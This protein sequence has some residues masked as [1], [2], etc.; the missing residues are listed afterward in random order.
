[1]G[2]KDGLKSIFGKIFGKNDPKLL[3]EKN[4]EQEEIN[5]KEKARKTEIR[6][7]QRKIKLDF[8]DSIKLNVGYE[9]TEKLSGIDKT[10]KLQKKEKVFG[11]SNIK[12]NI[13]DNI[14]LPCG[15]YVSTSE[16]EQAIDRALD[17]NDREN[18][19]IT[20]KEKAT[21]KS[22]SVQEL[23][24]KVIESV[25]EKVKIKLVEDSKQNIN[26]DTL[27]ISLENRNEEWTN[28]GKFMLER[29]KVQLPNGDFVRIK[30]IEEAMQNYLVDEEYEV[31]LVRFAT[32]Q[33]Q[34]ASITRHK[35]A[36]NNKNSKPAKVTKKAEK[37]K[38]S[39]IV[40][41]GVVMAS[42]G[43]TAYKSVQSLKGQEVDNG[44][45]KTVVGDVLKG[46]KDKTVAKYTLEKQEI[47]YESKEEVFDRIINNIGIGDKV[48]VGDGTD[49][50]GSSSYKAVKEED[51]V[52]VYGKDK[53]LQS[54]EA[55]IDYVSLVDASDNI[56]AVQY[57]KFEGESIG[58][59]INKASI[60]KGFDG[61]SVEIMVHISSEYKDENENIT[62]IPAGWTDF[63]EL[64]DRQDSQPQ[65]KSVKYKNT[66]EGIQYDYVERIDLE[67]GDQIQMDTIDPFSK[68]VKSA[69]GVIY[70]VNGIEK[71]TIRVPSKDGKTQYA[72][73]LENKWVISENENQAKENDEYER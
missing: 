63:R 50:H 33:E 31:S 36:K 13:S 65:I 38:F 51:T 73:R 17:G 68:T 71:I 22:I 70:K 25:R 29:G 67:N 10:I 14:D 1:M 26:Q 69:K 37:W 4:R 54:G 11:S 60:E 18:E 7:T 35:K 30:E 21:G 46:F 47:A 52:G 15:E 3:E 58:D 45:N 48:F 61:K 19:K 5:I 12:L 43:V 57:D 49:V 56:V 62:I 39:P 24:N 41:A 64:I 16:I 66:I 28:K 27:G 32:F 42:L 44:E 59:F 9:D 8:R 53:L 6:T 55:T 20:V 2:F 34:Q 40:L 23:K 72:D